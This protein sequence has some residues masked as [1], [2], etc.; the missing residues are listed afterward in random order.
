MHG[1]PS[2][3]WYERS[4]RYLA[5]FSVVL[6]VASTTAVFFVSGTKLG[7]VKDLVTACVGLL[8]LVISLQLEILFRIAERADAQH[9]HARLQE[10]IEDY[11]DLVPLVADA[12]RSSAVA[13]KESKTPEFVEQVFSIWRHASNRLDE[14]AQGRLRTDGS[15]GTIVLARSAHATR[16]IQGITDDRDVT[17]WLA[18]DGR[19]FLESNRRFI[20]NE[21]VVER[22]W[23]LSEAPSPTVRD[24]LAEHKAAGVR[25]FIVRADRL[26]RRLL[27]NLTLVDGSFLQEDLPNREGLSMEYLYSE[28]PTDLARAQSVFANLKSRSVSYEN[29]ASIQKLYP[30][31]ELGPGATP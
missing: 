5:F 15:D 22:V 21:G 29:E 7:D 20:G 30:P 25:L 16:S 19:S 17:W 26:D 2:P 14:L 23:I 3:R 24:L 8:G 1:R 11:P 9:R 27:V 10:A 31:G 28:N 12:S 18:E 13:L 6:T 4:G